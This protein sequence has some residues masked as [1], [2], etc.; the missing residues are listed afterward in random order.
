MREAFLGFNI[1][2]NKRSLALECY[3][4]D[5]LAGNVVLSWRRLGLQQTASETDRWAVR[6]TWPADLPEELCRE[7]ITTGRHACSQ[8]FHRA[9]FCVARAN[10]GR[11]LYGKGLE[12][13]TLKRNS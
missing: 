3:I 7:D 5:G 8:P 2:T 11:S 4:S 12:K 10:P 6:N 9:R 1:L 13:R